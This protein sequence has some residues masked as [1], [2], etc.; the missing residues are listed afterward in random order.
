M[1]AVS[2][3]TFSQQAAKVRREQARKQRQAKPWKPKAT[4]AMTMA[5]WEQRGGQDKPAKRKRI[6][7]RAISGGLPTLGKRRR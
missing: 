5:E 1:R 7:I 3:D 6:S 4:P 2:L